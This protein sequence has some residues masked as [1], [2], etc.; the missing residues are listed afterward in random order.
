MAELVWATTFFHL[1]VMLATNNTVFLIWIWINLPTTQYLFSHPHSSETHI[2]VIMQPCTPTYTKPTHTACIHTH[3]KVKF[4][5][6]LVGFLYKIKG[7][8][9]F[10]QLMPY[11]QQYKIESIIINAITCLSNKSYN[12]E[13]KQ[14][15][16]HTQMTWGP[17]PINFHT[18]ERESLDSQTDTRVRLSEWHTFL[19][20][21]CTSWLFKNSRALFTCIQSFPSTECH[22]APFLPTPS[23]EK[24]CM[25]QTNA[26]ICWPTYPI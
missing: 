5:C 9:N 22:P 3:R 7:L 15:S 17:N 8:L 23:C 20:N 1:I 26:T 11:G 13:H 16:K 14:K 2:P 24:Q 12:Y 21:Q 6:I 18:H 10:H 4:L 25:Q 19:Y